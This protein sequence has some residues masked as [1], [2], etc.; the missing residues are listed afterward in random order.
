MTYNRKSWF[1]VGFL[2]LT[3]TVVDFTL[4]SLRVT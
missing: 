3:G 4:W 1:H 2:P